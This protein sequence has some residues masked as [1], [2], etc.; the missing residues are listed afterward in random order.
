MAAALRPIYT[1]ANVE[2]ATAAL[3]TFERGAWGARLPTAVAVWRRAWTHV[4]PFSAFPP[5]VRRV[6]YTTHALQSVHAQLRKIIK[7]RGHS[8]RRG[9]HQAA[10]AGPRAYHGALDAGTAAPES[11]DESGRD[12]L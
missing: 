3:D 1:A 9:G 4:F 2:A 12:P 5:E 6:I 11:R 7:M 8:P 10:V